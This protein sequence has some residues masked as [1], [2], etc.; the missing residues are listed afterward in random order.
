MDLEQAILERRSIRRFHPEMP[1]EEQLLEVIRLA[2]AAP[3]PMNRQDWQF[4]ITHSPAIRE[5]IATAVSN[6]WEQLAAQAGGNED[7][8]RLHQGHFSTFREAPVLV[9]VSIKRTATFL[10]SLL[11]G[12][13]ERVQG[14]LLAAGMVIQNLQLA[15]HAKGLGSCVYTGCVA[16][17]DEISSILNISRG[18]RLVCLVA[19]GFPAETP[20]V[21]ARKEMNQFVTWVDEP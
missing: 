12:T 16:A 8:L 1:S 9:A 20:P 19:L 4:V 6:R 10:E 7:A 14:D 17:E 18:R 21:P 13:A 5:R 2:T 15:A 11:S 3:S